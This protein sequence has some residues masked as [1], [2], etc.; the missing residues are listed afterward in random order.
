MAGTAVALVL[1]A[2]REFSEPADW[3]ALAAA[4]GLKGRPKIAAAIDHL[5]NYSSFNIQTVADGWVLVERGEP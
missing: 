5:R 2:F 3:V 4:T 1:A